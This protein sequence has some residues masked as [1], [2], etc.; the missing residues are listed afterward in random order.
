MRYALMYCT[1]SS[2]SGVFVNKALLLH[3]MS[4]VKA[5]E[6]LRRA[7]VALL[8][9]GSVE[10]HGPHNPLGTDYLIAY[11]LAL[12]ASARTSAL[13]LPPIPF[14]VSAHHRHFP[15]TIYV[16]PGSLRA[17][18]RDVLCS[19]ADQGPRKVVIVNGHGGNLH[20]LLEV[21]RELRGERKA[22]VVVYQ[23]WDA[24]KELYPKEERGHA[25]SLETSLNLYLHKDLVDMSR[26]VDEPLKK[27]SY[28]LKG[29][30]VPWDTRDFTS[31]GV[32]GIST[33][34]SEAKG[35]EV[36]EKALKELCSLI[37]ELRRIPLDRLL[38]A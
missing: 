11:K 21:A 28:E 6:Q 16:K 7:D 26:A 14:G 10:Q 17:Y 12:Q 34:A 8:P 13:C 23:W 9:I 31:S 30:Y 19:L 3:E 27:L 4:W 33:T 35:K 20:S 25:A 38:K 15:G 24:I 18:V 22:F 1:T 2:L 5:E 37:E 29:V 36:F 32:M